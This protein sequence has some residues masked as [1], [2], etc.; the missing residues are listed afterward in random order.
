MLFLRPEKS[1]RPIVSIALANTSQAPYEVMLGCD[2]Q[3][4]NLRIP[5][6]LNGV[7]ETTRLDITVYHKSHKK[8]RRKRHVVG[9]AYV[10]LGE[11]LKRQ[12]RPGADLHIHLRCPPP[13]KRSPKLLNGRQAHSVT[14][15]V[16]MNAP[17][18]FLPSS[19]ASSTATLV[20]SPLVS[21][22]GS[23][24]E[25]E[26]SSDKAQETETPWTPNVPDNIL[27][28]MV[29]LRRRKC[30]R[31]KP[32]PYLVNSSDEEDGNCSS[33]SC[34]TCS[35]YDEKPSVHIF[36]CNDEND[37]YAACLPSV[38]PVLPQHTVAEGQQLSLAE[39][40]VDRF[41]PYR[42]MASPHCDYP[43]VQRRLLSEWYTVAG[44]LLALAGYV[45]PRLPERT[46]D[47]PMFRPG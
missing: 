34:A 15:I 47:L 13:Q 22:A 33:V 18:A 25:S 14:L 5:F 27:V 41:A 37:E 17:A 43:T 44:A 10:T 3:N 12:E 11:L 40:V 7:D 19:D 45:R 30:K 16:R 29:G 8:S 23:D 24:E 9:T 6:A 20:A 21:E 42:E 2:G 31:K 26:G 35:S 1:W 38:L 36:P 39:R 32:K 4:P 46:H 28:G